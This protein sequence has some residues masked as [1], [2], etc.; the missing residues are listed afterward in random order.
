MPFSISGMLSSLNRYRSLI[1]ISLV[2]VWEVHFVLFNLKLKYVINRLMHAFFHFRTVIIPRS[3]LTLWLKES[4]GRY[5]SLELITGLIWKRACINLRSKFF[6]GIV[7]ISWFLVSCLDLIYC[8]F[9]PRTFKLVDFPICCPWVYLMKVIL[10][11][12]RTYSM[13]YHFII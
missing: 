6:S 4:S 8:V 13:R 5:R 1:F 2:S 7:N 11:T 12:S 3:I 9:V 10:G